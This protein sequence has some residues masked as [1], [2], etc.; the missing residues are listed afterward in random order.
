MY[1]ERL[2]KRKKELG[3]TNKQL[4]EKSNV[5]LGTVN[6]IFSGATENPRFDTL[7]DL[8]EAMDMSL[9]MAQEIMEPDFKVAEAMPGYCPK[10]EGEY[11]VEDYLKLPGD[12]RVELIDG[13]FYTMEAPTINHQIIISDINLQLTA[14]VREKKGNCFVLQSPVDV[15]LFHDNKNMLQPDLLVLC[16]REKTDGKRIYGAPDMVVEVVSNGSRKKDYKIKFRK[17]SDAGV[18]EYWLVDMG[19][20]CVIKYM[21]HPEDYDV[22]LYSF[23]DKVPVGIYDGEAEVD[24]SVISQQM[25]PEV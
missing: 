8:A 6:K 21:F 20:R 25:L 7:C 13:S 4:A 14:Y 18:R 23:Q 9:F 19:K 3:L 16:D 24:F 2:K 10:K 22:A 12:V 11:T 15:K 5:S 17:Y 1:I